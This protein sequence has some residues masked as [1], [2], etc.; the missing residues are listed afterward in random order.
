MDHLFAAQQNN[1]PV[2]DLPEPEGPIGLTCGLVGGKQGRVLHI[3]ALRLL[4]VQCN[5]A[6]GVG[7]A[8]MFG[9]C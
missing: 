3:I 2:A 6:T 1:R 9:R 4:Q 8:A 7:V 5:C